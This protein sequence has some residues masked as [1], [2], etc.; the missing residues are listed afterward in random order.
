MPIPAFS[1]EGVLPPHT[2]NPANPADVSPFRCDAVDV[3]SRFA[4]SAERCRILFGW[5]E[6]RRLLREAGFTEAF[7]WLDGSFLEDVETR[8]GRPPRDQDVLTFFWPPH[9][10][11][12]ARVA[13]S[14]PVLTDHAA[15]KATF[16]VDHYPINLALHPVQTVDLV[17][18]WTGLFSHRRDGVWKGMARVELG[19]DTEDGAALPIL[20]ARQLSFQP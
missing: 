8:E 7:Q 1:T 12:T 10:E 11:F 15:V 18:Y 6:L 5:L 17:A 19:G 3:C 9:A 14:F 16:L 2:G 4:T 13:A 20:K